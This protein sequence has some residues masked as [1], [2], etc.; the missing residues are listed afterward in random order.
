M[1][2][3]QANVSPHIHSGESIRRIMWWVVAALMPAVVMSG[4]IFG[5][6]AIFLITLSAAACVATEAVVQR[7]RGVPVTALDGSAVITGM[8]LA[9]CIGTQV[10][11]YM[12]IAGD[13]VA[14]ALAKQLFGGLGMNIWN[15]ALVGRAFM[16]IAFPEEMNTF[17]YDLNGW[18]H[19]NTVDIVS[20][21][22]HMEAATVDVLSSATPLQAAHYQSGLDAH[23]S[24]IIPDLFFGCVS[25]SLGETSALALLIGGLILIA[26]GYVNWRMPLS[27]LASTAV[28]CMILP[29]KAGAIHDPLFHLFAG[30]LMLGAFFMATD[31]VTTPIT[32][33][34]IVV[35][36]IGCGLITSLI[37]MYGGYPEGVCFSILIMNTATPIIERFTRPR[38]YG[39]AAA[40]AAGAV[41]T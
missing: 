7:L 19:C 40:R 18:I 13:I 22:T 15:P 38:V 2:A 25:G 16:Q 41:K 36:G 27:Y 11:A 9:M 1:N 37:R 26:R 12:V 6:R 29:G 39:S 4:L 14:I 30:G 35:F 32:N 10:P 33:K 24:E 34:G 31:M 5:P 20:S 17:T 28:F 8:L 21:P 23:V 3:L